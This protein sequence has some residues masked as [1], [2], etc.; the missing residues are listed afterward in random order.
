MR[1]AAVK[2][3]AMLLTPLALAACEVGHIKLPM[4]LGPSNGPQATCLHS[5]D[6]PGDCRVNS[7]ASAH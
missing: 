6:A 5:A 2:W 7:S 3:L 4:T 1:R